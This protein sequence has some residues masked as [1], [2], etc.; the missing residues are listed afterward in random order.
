MNAKDM[1]IHHQD[2][3]RPQEY[4]GEYFVRFYIQIAILVEG[5]PARTETPLKMNSL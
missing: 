5:N 3:W 1:K 4:F 2:E